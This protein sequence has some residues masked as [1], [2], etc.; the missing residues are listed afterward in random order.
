[1]ENCLEKNDVSRKRRT[2]LENKQNPT[3]DTSLDESLDRITLAVYYFFMIKRL[4]N[5]ITIQQTLQLDL[6][7]KNCFKDEMAILLWLKQTKSVQKHCKNDF[8]IYPVTANKQL[9]FQT[10]NKWNIY[11]QKRFDSQSQLLKA[12]I[13]QNLYNKKLLI[14]KWHKVASTL[15]KR[16]DLFMIVRSNSLKNC[17][18]TS[19]NKWSRAH[20]YNLLIPELKH[21]L[22]QFAL[23][24]YPCKFFNIWSNSYEKR[25]A[26][27]QQAIK[28]YEYSMIKKVFKIMFSIC[29]SNQKRQKKLD[30]IT[31]HWNNK[32]SKL[33]F[34]ICNW[35]LYMKNKKSLRNT[36]RQNMLKQLKQVFELFYM[37]QCLTIWQE[38]NTQVT[39]LQRK[40][41]LIEITRCKDI[42][43]EWKQLLHLNTQA[44]H[45]RLNIEL[46]R[47]HY[48]VA[49]RKKQQQKNTIEKYHVAI[50][51][52]AAKYFKVWML[53]V[54][55][56]KHNRFNFLQVKQLD[57]FFLIYKEEHFFLNWFQL[58]KHLQN[59]Y[60]AWKLNWIHSLHQGYL[61]QLSCK[62]QMSKCF[63]KWQFSMVLFKKRAKLFRKIRWNKLNKYFMKWKMLFDKLNGIL[64]EH[65]EHNIFPCYHPLMKRYF[66]KW[67]REYIIK[68]FRQKHKAQK[69]KYLFNYWHVVTQIKI[70]SLKRVQKNQA[71]AQI[72]GSFSAWHMTV[73]HVKKQNYK[74][75]CLW[76]SQMQSNHFIV[77]PQKIVFVLVLFRLFR[78]SLVWCNYSVGNKYSYINIKR[79]KKKA[80]VQG[81]SKNKKGGQAP[82]STFSLY[83]YSNLSREFFVRTPPRIPCELLGETGFNN[84]EVDTMWESKLKNMKK[85]SKALLDEQIVFQSKCK[86]YLKG[87]LEDNKS[88]DCLLEDIMAFMQ[89]KKD[90][91]HKIFYFTR[92]IQSLHHLLGFLH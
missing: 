30:E 14:R 70:Q 53:V 5:R 85:F 36:E 31:K 72:W 86:S 12:Q 28:I 92:Q 33:R 67:I 6:A 4:F 80:H 77:S 71:K 89:Q 76:Y 15:Q 26:Q 19:I 52:S 61:N 22:E 41:M 82:L 40:C 65:K 68:N 47:W 48:C 43:L 60:K 7:A 51:H 45:F 39:K 91:Q 87:L 56:A 49:H 20:Q 69:R 44:R 25:Q 3:D 29:L 55:K 10:I 62:H 23:R 64:F 57:L 54:V 90:R 63:V 37:T 74:A 50:Y 73:V 13:L 38:Y 27:R 35:Q 32:K 34:I 11:C 46:H 75:I 21:L 16:R 83:A 24:L 1:M 84:D 18:R 88:D 17:V 58:Q 81:L 66:K 42:F 59:A 79:K 9:K 8:D 78:G 2:Y